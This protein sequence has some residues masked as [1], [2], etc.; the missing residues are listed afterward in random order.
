VVSGTSVTVGHE[1][2]CD[3]NELKGLISREEGRTV[4][5]DEILKRALKPL[6][7]ECRAKLLAV[8]AEEDTGE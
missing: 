8:I 4:P 7:A 3:L 5:Y 2:L 1:V 6:L